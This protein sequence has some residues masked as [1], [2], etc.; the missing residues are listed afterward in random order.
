MKNILR[1][2]FLSTLFHYSVLAQS[3]SASTVQTITLEVKSIARISVSGSPNPLVINDAVPGSNLTTVTDESSTYSLVTNT[4]NMKIV[5]SINNQMPSGT[6][7]KIRMGSS[8]AVSLG[9]VDLSD[10]TTPVDIVT[11]IGK[12]SE[13]N[14]PINYIFSADAEATEIP[15]QSRTITL[16]LTD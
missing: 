7:L 5:A 2:V 11:G 3:G 1:I 4:E 9:Y 15:S 13:I 8:Q 12:G 14:Q 10:A 16:T 6:S